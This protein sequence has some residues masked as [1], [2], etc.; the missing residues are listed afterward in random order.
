MVR[1]MEGTWKA[2]DINKSSQAMLVNLQQKGS[3]NARQGMNEI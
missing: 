1:T 2:E 3:S